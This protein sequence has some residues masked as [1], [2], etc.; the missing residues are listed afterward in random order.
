MALAHVLSRV[1]SRP[2]RDEREERLLLRDLALHVDV[3]IEHLGAV[4]TE[5]GADAKDVGEVAALAESVRDD[6]L[7]R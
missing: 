2:A 4:L 7:G 1:L 3:V 6:V 5:L